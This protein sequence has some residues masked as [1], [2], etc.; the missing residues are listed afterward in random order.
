MYESDVRS[1]YRYYLFVSRR[2]IEDVVNPCHLDKDS[3]VAERIAYGRQPWSQLAQASCHALA[4]PG[5]H[6]EDGVYVEDHGTNT[7]QV[8]ELR[9]CQLDKPMRVRR[10]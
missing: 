2:V 1:C 10:L 3:A 7:D 8:V 6:K 9:A 5:N 4:G